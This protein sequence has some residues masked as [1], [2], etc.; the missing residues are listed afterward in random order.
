M[1]K[2]SYL[3]VDDIMKT[4]RNE[5]KQSGV[6]KDHVLNS[7]IIELDH[8]EVT[9]IHAGDLKTNEDIAVVGETINDCREIVKSYLGTSFS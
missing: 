5:E 1:A 3:T 6:E 2:P 9:R 7:I 4:R 8:Y